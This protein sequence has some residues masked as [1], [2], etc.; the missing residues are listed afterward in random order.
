MK[1]EIINGQRVRCYD[2]GGE[3]FDRYT[4]VYLDMPDRKFVCCRGMSKYPFHP[5]GFGQFSSC[6]DGPHLGKR[7]SIKDLP[8]DCQKLIEQDTRP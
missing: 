5:Q 3:T 2:N 6:V 8:I 1:T 7:I 4:A